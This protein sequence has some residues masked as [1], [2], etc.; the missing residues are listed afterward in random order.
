VLK[1]KIDTRA[2]NFVKTIGA[3]SPPVTS[4]KFRSFQHGAASTRKAARASIKTAPKGQ[5]TG[6]RRKGGKK[7]RRAVH[8]AAPAGSPVRTQRGAYRKA[9]VYD[10]NEDGAIIGPR[11]SVI[12]TSGQAHEHGGSYRGGK[13]PQR[14]VMGPALELGAERF[15]ANWEGA[16]GGN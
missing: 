11:A 12:G 8:Q 2:V 5:K 1:V 4:A 16:I 14:P 3:K 10:A 7:V 6:G 15:A 9:I 13:Y